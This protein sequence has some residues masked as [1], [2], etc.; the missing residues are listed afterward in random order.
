MKLL[1]SIKLKAY[2]AA[3]ELRMGFYEQRLTRYEVTSELENPIECGEQVAKMMKAHGMGGDILII[4]EVMGMMAFATAKQYHASFGLNN[5]G[6]EH[7]TT[8][9]VERKA[10]AAQMKGLLRL[11]VFQGITEEQFIELVIAHELGHISLGHPHSPEIARR[12]EVVEAVG[13]TIESVQNNV[14]LF[15]EIAEDSIRIEL[16]AWYAGEQFV[17]PSLVPY[18][19]AFN[20][21][22]VRAY[23]KRYNQE[24]GMKLFEL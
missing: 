6:M 12:K 5:M 18:Y 1:T 16:E 11:P 7:S 14:E 2:N 19:D 10:L 24:L 3:Y 8:L 23:K 9:V 22:N 17:S 4:D 15:K 13:N 21:L 20:K